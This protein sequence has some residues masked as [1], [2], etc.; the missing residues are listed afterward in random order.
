MSGYGFRGERA[1]V[2]V[3]R[4]SPPDEPELRVRHIA[5]YLDRALTSGVPSVTAE[6]P[7]LLVTAS[8]T[9]PVQ[10]DP[11]LAEQL[12]GAPRDA[13]VRQGTDR[14]R[15]AFLPGGERDQRT[16]QMSQAGRLEQIT[17]DPE[18]P[19]RTESILP[20]NGLVTYH[21]DRFAF[22][23]DRDGQS[24]LTLMGT[25]RLIYQDREATRTLTLAA[26]D[27]VIFMDS[28]DL[29]DAGTLDATEIR[30]MYLE[31]GVV[32]TD[33]EYTAR[34]PRAFYDLIG[35]RAVLLEAVM[36]AWDPRR[37]IPLYLRADVLRQTAQ[38]SFEAERA[39]LTTS[40]FA[41]PHFAIGARRLTVRPR[42]QREVPAGT[43]GSIAST[44]GSS[45]G[46]AGA[47][48]TAGDGS[49]NRN[50]E[51]TPGRGLIDPVASASAGP[52]R[53]YAQ[54]TTLEFLQ[55]PFFWWPRLSGAV[56]RG[57]I[58]SIQI[59]T[60]SDLGVTLETEWDLFAILG[61][62]SPQGVDGILRVDWNG[63]HQLGLGAD[64]AWDRDGNADRGERIGE[65][66]G[67]IV[68]DEQ[69]IDEIGR[70]RDIDRNGETRGMMLLRDR[71]EIFEGFEVSLEGAYVSDETFLE[72][73]F[74][75]EATS[76]KAYETSLY[77]NRYGD[78][79]AFT[80]LAATDFNNFQAQLPA[81]QSSP[82]TVDRLPEIGMY[83]IGRPV[84]NGAATYFAQTTASVLRL[85][86]Y[87]DTPGDRGIRNA[88]S[89]IA[90][91]IP[92]AS[93]FSS[94]PALTGLPDNYVGRFD[95]R[96]ELT[97]PLKFRG[98]DV[99]PYGIA[100]LTAYDDSFNDFRGNEDRLRLWGGL[101][102]RAS[103]AFTR[104]SRAENNLLDLNGMRHIIEPS[105]DAY[106]LGSTIDSET[107]PVFDPDIEGISDRPGVRFGL[108]NTWQTQR[109]EPGDTRSVDW[110]VWDTSFVLTADDQPIATVMPRGFSYRPE[111]IRGGNH[112]H[113][114]LRW[115]VTETLAA[116]GE[117][118]YALEPDRVTDRLAQWR[119]GATLRPDPAFN[120]FVSFQEIA[121]L[122]TTL[123]SY[124][125]S[126]ALTDKYTIGFDQ[127]L[128][129]SENESRRFT[130]GLTRKLPGWVMR[131]A[132]SVDEIDGETAVGFYLAPDGYGGGGGGFNLFDD[133]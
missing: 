57:P 119:V 34:A 4:V 71:Q 50:G 5:V 61:A 86:F 88:D 40:E 112:A 74:P 44:G 37:D 58:R 126:V 60:S 77:L 69:G 24:V 109:G 7:R 105:V 12:A 115:R 107:L 26:Q 103:T 111:L 94:D 75:R 101:G 35:D 81:L 125:F 118:T 67:Y 72:E 97:M 85:R 31:G 36:Y 49:F 52:L 21:A 76:A 70:R 123:L 131:V 64:L 99:T 128:D 87:D 22:E 28:V 106:V 45:A 20:T 132:A 130:I 82:Y 98:V 92:A 62:E 9:G 8:T 102:V 55:T 116:N 93:N 122:D 65:F 104:I 41:A 1:L 23:P 84:F 3:D 2:R 43:P 66:R 120:A 15:R 124:G 113:S 121:A 54:D 14:I 6:A 133:R 100:R 47:A 16:G 13:F 48:G 80:V 79:W 68:P 95:S 59:G 83:R 127:R 53:Y 91:G 18:D 39:L 25:V 63:E 32:I 38:Q 110:V 19:L 17:L 29:A 96:H 10:I 117:I 78:D 30:G 42:V 56:D 11:A 27:A 89:L 46:N 108:R 90:L 51:G 129:F 114:A 33:G 73:Y